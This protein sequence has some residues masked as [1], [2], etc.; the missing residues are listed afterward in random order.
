MFHYDYMT[1]NTC[2]QLISMDL[3]GDAVR[4]LPA[5]KARSSLTSQAS[6]PQAA[7]RIEQ[8]KQLPNPAGCGPN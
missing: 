8:T 4:S 7:A 3:D 1:E 6:T 5:A 2:S